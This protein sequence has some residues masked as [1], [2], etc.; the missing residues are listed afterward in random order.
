MACGLASMAM[1]AS[2]QPGV[3]GGSVRAAARS[4]VV[5]EVADLAKAQ[6]W[7][8]EV[9]GLEVAA[10]AG[11]A[12]QCEVLLPVPASRLFLRQVA[13]PK[14][15][16]GLLAFGVADQADCLRKLVAHKVSLEQVAAKLGDLGSVLVFKDPDG[17]RLGIFEEPKGDGSPLS[18][19]SWLSG[20]WRSRDPKEGME[21][22]WSTAAGGTMLGMNRQ[23]RGP[24]TSY[25][26]L[27]LVT[28]DAKVV[29]VA[30]PSGQATTEFELVESAP[31]I[32]VFENKEHDFP[33]KIAYRLQGSG[34]LQV[35]ISA[36]EGETERGMTFTLVRA[37][38]V[39]ER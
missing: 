31:G 16:G 10:G 22:H 24:R 34:E 35:R 25:E 21:E 14:T 29:Y 13:E 26:F 9:L 32:A 36:T 18:A 6:A 28:R 39:G 15:G 12:R 37:G 3:I 11:D 8:R 23:V 2:A 38:L 30:S 17:N 1:A 27:R 5:F 19:L 7:Y 4:L 33:Q 20:S